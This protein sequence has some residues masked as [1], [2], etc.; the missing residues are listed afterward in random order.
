MQQEEQISVITTRTLYCSILTMTLHIAMT[1]WVTPH[2]TVTTFMLI[3]VFSV[4][5]LS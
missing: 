3:K 5:A 1:P 2:S 4:S